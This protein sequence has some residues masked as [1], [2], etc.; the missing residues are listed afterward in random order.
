MA[1]SASRDRLWT[2]AAPSITIGLAMTALSEAGM[3]T[4]EIRYEAKLVLHLD[5]AL[6]EPARLALLDQVAAGLRDERFG[7]FQAFTEAWEKLGITTDEDECRLLADVIYVSA[8]LICGSESAL[9]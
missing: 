9:T 4:T 6:V 7:G 8:L 2:I 3:T 1:P 5:R